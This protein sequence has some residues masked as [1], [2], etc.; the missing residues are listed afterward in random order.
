MTDSTDQPVPGPPDSTTS[1]GDAIGSPPRP[2]RPSYAALAAA[3]A[4]GGTIPG[5][6]HAMRDPPPRPPRALKPAESSARP[7]ATSAVFEEP[8]T[9]A[10]PAL[11]TG[12][13]GPRPMSTSP[14]ATRPVESYRQALASDKPAAPS[15]DNQ[16]PADADVPS[17]DDDELRLAGNEGYSAPPPVCPTTGRQAIRVYGK[18]RKSYSSSRPAPPPTAPPTAKWD[19]DAWGN[20]SH[21]PLGPPVASTSTARYEGTGRGEDARSGASWEDRVHAEYADQHPQDQQ[22][23]S[24]HFVPRE[25]TPTP[26]AIIPPVDVGGWTT[27]RVLVKAG[28]YGSKP[29][30]WKA[31]TYDFDIHDTPAGQ[32]ATGKLIYPAMGTEIKVAE[33]EPEPAPSDAATTEPVQDVAMHDPEG[34]QTTAATNAS[35]ASSEE[36]P[37]EDPDASKP[38]PKPKPPR[39]PTFRTVSRAE[40]DA[41]RPHPA[42]FFCPHTFSWCFFAKIHD[43]E[44]VPPNE[45]V[46]WQ[47]KMAGAKEDDIASW[48][49]SNGIDPPPPDPIAP[50]HSS[51][52]ADE[53][54]SLDDFE[55]GGLIEVV[56]NHGRVCAF[57]VQDWYPTVISTH[58]FHDLLDNRGRNPGT[59]YTAS[60]A[61]YH[62]VRTIWRFLD[63]L[64]FVGEQR[65]L[66]VTGKVFVRNLG[67][68]RHSETILIRT[69]GAKLVEDRHL[70][71]DDVSD[72]TESGR[73]NRTRLLRC[74]LELLL[75]LEHTRRTDPKQSED[76]AL[77][78]RLSMRDARQK[79][80]AVMG[81]GELPV[82]PFGQTWDAPGVPRLRLPDVDVELHPLASEFGDLGVTPNVADEV[83]IKIY[84]LK[85]AHEDWLVPFRFSA[86][87]RIADSRK[88]E[89][90]GI[91]VAQERSLG[92]HAASEITAAYA[93]LRLPD[94]FAPQSPHITE[95][96]LVEALQTRIEEVEH[97]SRRAV[98]LQAARIVADY[99][100]S[101]YF[102][103]VLES[104]AGELGDAP[105]KPTM[106]LDAACRALGIEKETEDDL[107]LMTYEIRLSDAEN[108]SDK[109]KIKE[110]LR[111]VA[112]ARQ[113]T[114]LQKR[115]QSDTQNTD[116]G[117][118][119]AI[120]ADPRI[121]VG[122][123]NIANTCY[124]NSLLQYF[125]TIREMRETILAFAEKPYSDGDEQAQIR[126]GGRLV[127]PAE[128]KRSKRFVILLKTLFE[129][130]IHAPVS[131]VTPETEL[132]Y[133]ALVPS[134]EEVEAAAA[135]ATSAPPLTGEPETIKPDSSSTS[136]ASPAASSD[137]VKS[138][139]SVLGKRKNGDDEEEFM[140]VDLLSSTPNKS[141][142]LL[143]ERDLNR[144]TD[145][146]STVVPTTGAESGELA[147][148]ESDYPRIK[149]GR[150]TD[151]DKAEA[152]SMKLD[153]VASPAPPPPLPPRPT[154]TAAPDKEKELERQVS[155]Y[156]AFGRQN[157]VTECMDN[158]MFQVE[159]ALLANSRNGH[160]E[161]T[162]N[163]LRKTFF[164][165]MRQQIAFDEPADV[166]DPLRSQDEPF[167]SLL[168]DVPAMSATTTPGLARDIYDALDT[169]FEPSQVELESRSARRHIRLIAPPPPVL[170]V[171]LQRVQ[172]DRERQSVYKSNAHLAFE[173]ELDVGR[174]LESQDHAE[175]QAKH[176][177]TDAA[178]EELKR[179]RARLAELTQNNTSTAA[180]LVR[181]TLTHSR[182]LASLLS[183]TKASTSPNTEEDDLMTFSDEEPAQGSASLKKLLNEELFEATELEVKALEDEIE[184]LT[185]R[186][187]ELK[188]EMRRLWDEGGLERKSRYKLTAV[189]IHRGTALSGHYYIYQRD[190]RE[191]K[192]WL[193]YNDS[194]VT[195]VDADEIFRE[196]T[197]DTNAYFLSYVRMDCL[198]AVETIK[199]EPA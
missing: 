92:R 63:N 49:T 44:P 150:S 151:G 143:G 22:H 51:Q 61:R 95:E 77:S 15:E 25:V 179:V 134:R 87:C 175:V 81:Q 123:T 89:A 104:S 148:E 140:Q 84:D 180:T 178:R 170:Q 40:L 176:A 141:E 70:V 42:L 192:R 52:Q 158:V 35:Q 72:E 126:V 133:L 165:T 14:N 135:A 36:D 163:L 74:W 181:S 107:V 55:A 127:S 59:G 71:F 110:A 164:G 182:H 101:E 131:A 152:S 11:P 128:I 186:A 20:G 96:A 171:Q 100:R 66:P 45:L 27:P 43:G 29:G 78:S 54:S 162:A 85:C 38:K 138:P 73:I 105:A 174:Y 30:I 60:E 79:I 169:L 167:S 153:Q 37:I 2:Q 160:A 56:S 68:D 146:P 136:G 142:R 168:L 112:D 195:E 177:R 145:P 50:A 97:P 132:A 108:D 190:P 129:Q 156:M 86:L 125:F 130:L 106:D 18:A 65:G 103:A 187:V 80:G 198:D 189:F 121:P 94:P 124:L 41:I 3:A 34:S 120:A 91:K 159:A 114:V 12:L 10:V 183:A 23:S 6:D 8:T 157:D 33:S 154:T 93:E 149:R 199:R 19:D 13:R 188:R 69:L 83:I 47:A 46:L 172:Y 173:D 161:E 24:R 119:A 109:V 39:R 88:S 17:S 64:L 111:V 155:T 75:W 82:V 31:T 184:L 28:E 166:D 116:A 58:D 118:E 76:N 139:S 1:K 53:Q 185:Q 32:P 117:W 194:V 193:K 137:T 26:V 62:A 99:A 113:S 7:V 4:A 147:V 115:L 122:L 57:S 197:G 16:V 9:T 98:L 90:L 5:T 196:T 67:W 21:A 144:V 48:F 191:E 102:K